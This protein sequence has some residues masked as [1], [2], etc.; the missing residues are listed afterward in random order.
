MNKN[1]VIYSTLTGNTKEV[2][3]SIYSMLPLGSEIFSS[4]DIKKIDFNEFKNIFL[5]FWVD[6][7]T[8]DPLAQVAIQA[9]KNKNVALFG[10]V[11]APPDMV[12]SDGSAPDYGTKC[13]NN[14]AAL[15]DPSCKIVTRFICQGRISAKMTE[16]F[17]QFPA[18]HPHAMTPERMARHQAS[19]AHPDAKDLD[20][21]KSFALESLKRLDCEAVHE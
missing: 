17:K 16:A 15:F 18:G 4:A 11:G 2:A 12:P 6:K 21:A 8:A 13:L 20:A 14:A 9:L 19:Q 10:T 1:L 7:G 3:E 5:G